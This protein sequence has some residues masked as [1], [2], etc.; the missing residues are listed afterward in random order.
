MGKLLNTIKHDGIRVAGKK[1]YARGENMFHR[2]FSTASYRIADR[3]PVFAPYSMG[4]YGARAKLTIL[5]ANKTFPLLTQLIADTRNTSLLEVSPVEGF[6]RDDASRVA[7]LALKA[8]FDKYGSDKS[9]GHKYE[10]LYGAILR[11]P[12]SV[13]S[14]LEIGLGTNNIGVVSHMGAAGRPGASLRAFRDYLPK[15]MIYGADVD[16][17]ILFT[18][19]RIKTFF[20][21]QTDLSTFDALGREVGDG[22]DLIIDDGLHCPNANIAVLLFA[23]KRLK[24]GGWFVAEDIPDQALPVWQV[25]AALM[26]SAYKC[27]LIAAGE[28]NMFSAQRLL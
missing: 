9:R 15:A 26:P 4:A 20:V 3:I 19:N 7:A 18:E 1:L 8:L 10:H 23:M 22:L 21:D 12:A 14:M 28:A 2:F 11:D 5:A 24:R 25:V 16:S 17:T 13:T 6:C 27:S